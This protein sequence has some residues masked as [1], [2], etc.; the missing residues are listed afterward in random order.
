MGIGRRLGHPRSRVLRRAVTDSFDGTYSHDGIVDVATLN[1]WIARK[2]KP[3]GHSLLVEGAAG[4]Y[5]RFFTFGFY[6]PGDRPRYAS[7]M[8]FV[9][10]HGHLFLRFVS[11][12]DYATLTFVP[13]WDE[14]RV[15]HNLLRQARYA[16][17]VI[18]FYQQ[19][20]L[21]Y[22]VDVHALGTTRGCGSDAN[23]FYVW[24]IDPAL[25]DEEYAVPAS[26]GERLVS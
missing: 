13:E 21:P 10:H 2:G 15:G 5:D 9:P 19:C 17:A 20:H 11:Y 25:G 4:I 14:R 18:R 8:A 26:W 3:V 23:Q 24:R 6:V 7:D 12:W 16:V 22:V 1:V